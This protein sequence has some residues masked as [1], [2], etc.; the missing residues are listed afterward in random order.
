V[1]TWFRHAVGECVACGACAPPN[2]SQSGSDC[3]LLSQQTIEPVSGPWS[4]ATT[5]RVRPAVVGPPLATAG[6]VAPNQVVD[7]DVT[8]AIQG[9]GT[10][11]FA[12]VSASTDYVGY[13]S[14]EAASGKPQ[15]IVTLGPPRLTLSGTFVDSYYNASLAAGTRIDARGATFLGSDTNSYPLNLGGGPG[16]VLAG[17]QGRPSGS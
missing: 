11:N 7:F 17:G 4:E 6:A 5:Y 2:F 10:V 8:K 12:L 13:R 3:G 16:V 1:G 15:L 14:R 9:D